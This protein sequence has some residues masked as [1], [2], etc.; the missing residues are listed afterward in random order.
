MKR[1]FLFLS[2][3]ISMAFASAQETHLTFEITGMDNKSVVVEHYGEKA[4]QVFS[5]NADVTGK[6]TINAG[7]TEYGFY[8]INLD[9]GKEVFFIVTGPGEKI[10]FRSNMDHLIRDMIVEGSKLNARY[11]KVKYQNDSIRGVQSKLEQEHKQLSAT[12]GNEARL[13]AI[14]DMHTRLQT[15]RLAIVRT[16]MAENSDALS[17]LFFTEDVKLEDEP[18]LYD[19]MVADLM[20]KFPDNHFVK[21]INRKVMVERVT[22]I[23]SLAPDIALPN[24]DGDTIRLSSLRG[25]IVLLDFWAAWCGPCRRENPNLVRIYNQYKDKGFEIYGVSLDRDRASWLKGI[26]EDKLTWTLVSDLKY[27]SSSAA[28][29]YGVTSIPY[30]VLLDREGRIIAKKIRAHDLERILAEM[31]AE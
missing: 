12:P 9:K 6:V 14:V 25:N 15:E 4:T 30:A 11:L 19:K 8:R 23:G 10:T 17:V 18:L 20:K 22:R 5:G 31:F 3:I 26:N 29:L 27:W 16:Y 24:P 1:L 7:L 21:D 28:K 2:A 13:Q